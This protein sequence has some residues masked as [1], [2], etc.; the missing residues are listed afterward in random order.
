MERFAAGRSRAQR[1]IGGRIG[2]GLRFGRGFRLLL[3]YM[4]A[5]GGN[6]LTRALLTDAFD[7]ECGLVGVSEQLGGTEAK[8]VQQFGIDVADAGDRVERLACVARLF[9]GLR[10]AAHVELPSGE[11]MRE[12][13]VLTA[14]ADRE[15]ELI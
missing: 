5:R 11:A 15:R 4:L 8:L 13:H 1:L 6:Q 2:F 14:L 7:I 12:A 3:A 10:L 9:F